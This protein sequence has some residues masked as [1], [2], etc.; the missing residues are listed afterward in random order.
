M[1]DQIDLFAPTPDPA[2]P[3]APPDVPRPRRGRKLRPQRP[4]LVA[5]VLDLIHHGGLGMLDASDRVVAFEDDTRVRLSTD[6]DITLSLLEQRYVERR[7]PRDT[8]TCL[9]GA[10]RK[11]VTPLRLTKSGHKLLA[12]WTALRPL[13]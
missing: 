1:S 12:R 2:P 7:P 4:E 13:A 9:H 3:T 6:E 5:E 8:V 10:V 11:P